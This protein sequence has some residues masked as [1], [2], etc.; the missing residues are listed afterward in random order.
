MNIP[1]QIKE[2]LKIVGYFCY[3]HTNEVICDGDACIIAG[4]EKLMQSYLDNMAK[5]NERRIIKKTR[6]NE[7]LNGLLQGGAY[8]IDEEAYKRF[9]SVAHA[10]GITDLPS[11]DFFSTL[12]ATG[13]H[14]IR[15]QWRG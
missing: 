14:F 3:T 12:S 1:K 4:N 10:N 11:T 15:I 5:S 13:M 8:A 2:G 6:F 9:Y 7:I